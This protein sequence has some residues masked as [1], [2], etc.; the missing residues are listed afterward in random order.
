MQPLLP[1]CLEWPSRHQAFHR[2]DLPKNWRSLTWLPRFERLRDKRI[3]ELEEVGE[4][5]RWRL[6][7]V[8]SGGLVYKCILYSGVT[9]KELYQST[10]IFFGD[11]YKPLSMVDVRHHSLVPWSR[12]TSTI[13]NG[14]TSK[15]AVILAS[16][17]VYQ[18]VFEGCS[19][20]VK[21]PL[22]HRH[23]TDTTRWMVTIMA[24]W[25]LFSMTV[26]I[27]RMVHDGLLPRK[28]IAE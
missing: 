10:F 5:M 27:K 23:A 11:Y 26:L 17:L 19:L 24:E 16:R 22:T 7:Q 1:G 25:F 6:Q 20:G 14:V 3:K 13:Y 8:E 15:T 2:Y 12:G 9:L 28:V 21:G 18:R 4:T